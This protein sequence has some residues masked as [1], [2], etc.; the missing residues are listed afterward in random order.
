VEQE[1]RLLS[2]Q[3]SEVKKR[4]AADDQAVVAAVR[5]GDELAFT[6]MAE[7]YRRQLRNYCYRMLGSLEDAEDLVQDTF[8]RALRARTAATGGGNP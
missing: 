4:S 1:T 2:R 3:R 7:G 6:R 5:A 8:L